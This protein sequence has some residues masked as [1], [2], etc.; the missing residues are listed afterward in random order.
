MITDNFTFCH[1]PVIFFYLFLSK[2]HFPISLCRCTLVTYVKLKFYF[3]L[4]LRVFNIEIYA[5]S[6]SLFRDSL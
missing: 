2:S 3:I 6:I 5:D 1:F 4:F